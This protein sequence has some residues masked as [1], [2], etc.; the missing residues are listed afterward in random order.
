L[1]PSA[2]GQSGIKIIPE[3]TDPNDSNK[4]AAKFGLTAINRQSFDDISHDLRTNFLASNASGFEAAGTP[5][6]PLGVQGQSPAKGIGAGS[7][8]RMAAM[9]VNSQSVNIHQ[10]AHQN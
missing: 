5:Y 8:P 7:V 9:T 6:T 10:S 4:S 1:H 2:S 3:E